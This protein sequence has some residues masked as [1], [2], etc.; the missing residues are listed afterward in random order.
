M[1]QKLHLA[2]KDA[3]FGQNIALDVLVNGQPGIPLAQIMWDTTKNSISQYLITVR[4]I[5]KELCG[6][7]K[8]H[9]LHLVD[10]RSPAVKWVFLCQQFLFDKA[11]GTAAKDNHY[12]GIPQLRIPETLKNRG[13]TLVTTAHIRKFIDHQ[14]LFP[15]TVW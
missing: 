3:A 7:I 15:V 14:Q 8:S 5:W 9:F 10:T 6:I 13:N 12:V 1:Q 4:I 2:V 11:H